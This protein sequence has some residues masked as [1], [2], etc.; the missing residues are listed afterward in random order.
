[1]DNHK[2]DLEPKI[3]ETAK[4][5]FVKYGYAEA[6]MSIIAQ[7]MGISRTT[8]HYYFRTKDRLFEA[9]GGSIV[10]T[11]APQVT[12]IVTQ[13]NLSIKERVGLIVDAYYVVFKKHPRL[14][15]FLIGE[16][17][18]DYDHMFSVMYHEGVFNFFY[19]LVNDLKKV[20]ENNYI[21]DV[22]LR[23]VGLT[24]YSMLVMPFL[25]QPVCQ[26]VR[27]EYETFDEFLES[28]KKTICTTINTQ[29]LGIRSM[30]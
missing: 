18:R 15:V 16:L 22:S 1:M 12:N 6:S 21:H 28:W 9:V 23:S 27:E 20:M 24:F 7:E 14:P 3:I 11:I 17:N 19:A 26:L 5:C 13:E 2:E 4:E 29:L 10:S 25:T 30:Y 8:L